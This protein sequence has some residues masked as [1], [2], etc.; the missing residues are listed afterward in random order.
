MDSKVC[1][2]CNKLKPLSSYHKH[3]TGKDK[4]TSECK[5]CKRLRDKEYK[6]FKD[7]L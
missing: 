2:K 7:K 6:F 5:V 1:T 3:P 4:H